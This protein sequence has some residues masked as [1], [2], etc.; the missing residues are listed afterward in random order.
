MVNINLEP[1]EGGTL[2]DMISATDEGVLMSANRSWSIDDHRL[3]FQFGCEL[4]REIKGGKL[5][6]L[7]RN[8]V[9]TGIT[10]EFWGSCDLVGGTQSWD[11]WGW[12]YCGKGDPMQIMHVGHGTPPARFKDVQVRSS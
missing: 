9:Y 6:Q 4:A 11:M 5:G 12:F 2:E 8:P 10:P 1:G 7:Y 3:N